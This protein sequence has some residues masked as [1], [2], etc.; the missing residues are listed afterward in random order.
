MR[1]VCFCAFDL[2]AC[3][4]HC[5][6]WYYWYSC[7]QSQQSFR[8]VSVCVCVWCN[9]LSVQYLEEY[10]GTE[11]IALI[12]LSDWNEFGVLLMGNPIFPVNRLINLST[13]SSEHS[14]NTQIQH[15]KITSILRLVE[16]ALFD[17]HGCMEAMQLVK[18]S[19][20]HLRELQGKAIPL[21]LFIQKIINILF[22]LFYMGIRLY[23]PNTVIK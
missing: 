4:S 22:I 21:W 2:C 3:Q 18:A 16:I 1:Q 15:V 12:I 6:Y 9:C 11:L 5:A 23:G 10:N 20:L 19:R 14:Q 7:V 8:L 13:G 17:L